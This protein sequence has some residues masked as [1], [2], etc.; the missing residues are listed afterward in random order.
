MFNG[1]TSLTTAP[2]LPATTLAKYCYSDMFNNCKNLN[3]VKAMFT[4]D[5]SLSLNYL[6]SWLNGVSLNG[7]FVK[8]ANAT[9]TNEAAEIP[10]GW[11]VETA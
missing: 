2:E 9:W 8:S 1:C 3:Y 6:S 5:K 7:T 4:T 11:T 10:I